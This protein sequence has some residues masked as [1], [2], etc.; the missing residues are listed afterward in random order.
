MSHPAV[1]EQAV[2]R[3]V[4][5]ADSAA[6]GK[7]LLGLA[8]NHFASHVLE[9]GRKL[10]ERLDEAV[11]KTTPALH[12]T[13]EVASLKVQSADDQ[14]VD[15]LEAMFDSG[16]QGAEHDAMSIHAVFRFESTVEDESAAQTRHKVTVFVEDIVKD[17]R[18]ELF[19]YA[20]DGQGVSDATAFGIEDSV[21]AIDATL[22]VAL[23]ALNG[24]STAKIFAG[25][26]AARVQRAQEI[27]ERKARTPAGTNSR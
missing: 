2:E 8:H 18:L 25:I 14:C 7:G 22:G 15:G 19:T 17:E 1:A 13:G 10:F 6:A 3:P 23:N 26:S 5:P 11:K 12:R 4:L 9:L 24:E 27:A 16:D 20:A 21:K